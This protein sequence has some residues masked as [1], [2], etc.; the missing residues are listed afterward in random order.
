MTQTNVFFFS[1]QRDFMSILIVSIVWED[2]WDAELFGHMGPVRENIH[3]WK[4]G[5]EKGEK[6]ADSKQP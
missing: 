6:Q 3:M 2:F 1:E 4:V 5:N